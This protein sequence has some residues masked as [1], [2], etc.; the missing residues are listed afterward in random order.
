M[1][2]PFIIT[3]IIINDLF[4]LSDFDRFF[5]YIG[6]LLPTYYLLCSYLLMSFISFKYI[7]YK[8]IVTPSVLI[9]L[10]LIIYLTISILSLLMPDLKDSMGYA[11]LILISLFYYLG[12]C[13]IVYLRNRYTYGY[14]LLIAAISCIL[15]NAVLPIQELYYHNPVFEAVIYSAD[16]I[17][18]F[19]YLKFLIC[20]EPVENNDS[21]DFF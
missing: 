7:R 5:N 9:G 3:V 12:C 19:F 18:M 6:V 14:F 20:T 4:V 11:T 1:L 17:A 10:L 16:V 2:Y 21:P 8:E 15:V 13:F